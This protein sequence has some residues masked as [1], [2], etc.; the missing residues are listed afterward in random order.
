[1]QYIDSRSW[2]YGFQPLLLVLR[3]GWYDFAFTR[4]FATRVAKSYH[5][6]RKALL[7]QQAWLKI[8]QPTRAH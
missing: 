3:L 8:I 6:A 5:P 2:L 1:M 7:D 4:G